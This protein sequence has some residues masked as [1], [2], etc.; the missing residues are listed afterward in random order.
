MKGLPWCSAGCAFVQFRTWAQAEAAI[1]MHN[2]N[3]RLGNAEVPLVVKFA[4]AKRRDTAGPMG[5][6]PGE[7]PPSFRRNS[8]APGD[9]GMQVHGVRC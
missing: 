4:D 6:R 2:A 8:L 9:M 1:D 3:T 5:R 7:W